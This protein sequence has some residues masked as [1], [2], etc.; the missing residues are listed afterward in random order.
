[1]FQFGAS[2]NHFRK[3]KTKLKLLQGFDARQ[4]DPLNTTACK[5]VPWKREAVADDEFFNQGSRISPQK[6]CYSRDRR[7]VD[8]L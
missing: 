2:A 7:R 5:N 3:Q 6:A 4:M 8:N 1:M